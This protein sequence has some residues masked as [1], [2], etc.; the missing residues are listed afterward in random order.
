VATDLAPFPVVCSGSATQTGLWSYG[1]YALADLKLHGRQRVYD[2]EVR[3]F[4]DGARFDLDLP[5]QRGPK[6]AN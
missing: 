3:S 4:R 6:A 2:V 1:E 5:V